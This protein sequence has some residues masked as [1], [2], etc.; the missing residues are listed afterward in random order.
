MRVPFNLEILIQEFVLQKC[1]QAC[2]II[3]AKGYLLFITPELRI[4]ERPETN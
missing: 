3:F 2:E 4:L 1:L